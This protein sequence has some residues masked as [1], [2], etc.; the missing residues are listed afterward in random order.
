MKRLFNF[1]QGYGLINIFWRIVTIQLTWNLASQDSVFLLD[2][3]YWL[4]RFIGF[5]PFLKQR[6]SIKIRK[7]NLFD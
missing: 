4:I 6:W 1:C 3:D 7:G 2:L 5:I